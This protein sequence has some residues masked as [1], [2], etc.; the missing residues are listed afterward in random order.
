MPNSL[1]SFRP[2]LAMTVAVLTALPVLLGLGTWQLQRLAW[3]TE[4]IEVVNSRSEARP[5]P[6]PQADALNDN[7]NHR[8][9]SLKGLWLAGTE[10][11]VPAKT[12][13]RELGE[14]LLQVMSLED[15]RS[16]L[17]NRG[18][19][20]LC[21]R[22]DTCREPDPSSEQTV[23]GILRLGFQRGPLVPENEPDEARWFWFDIPAIEATLDIGPLLPVVI[24]V[25]PDTDVDGVPPIPQVPS[26][27]LRNQHLSYALTW[28]SLAI[29]MLGVYFAFGMRRGHSDRLE[30]ARKEDQE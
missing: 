26:L 8:A 13:D 30:A 16:V 18:W 20:P 22:E 23:E 21:W 9:V 2:G 14:W 6:L 25:H 1:K 10:Q 4:L 7:W 19:V 12:H 24:F 15:G 5:V 27:S 28:Y 29:V 3:K 17:V 11:F